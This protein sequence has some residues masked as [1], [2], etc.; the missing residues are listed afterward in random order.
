MPWPVLWHG[1]SYEGSRA[2]ALAISAAQA[3]HRLLRTYEQIDAF[4]AMSGFQKS[5][6][7]QAG[8]RPER[9]HVKPHFVTPV[10]SASR[11]RERTFVYVGQL[12]RSKGVFALL[13]A[14][15]Q[16]ALSDWSLELIGTGPDEEKIRKDFA[17][18]EGV[19]F[20]GRLP[21]EEA[22]ERV[23]E[24]RYLVLPTRMLE[25]FGL[26]AVEAMAHGAVALVS[27]LGLLP[28]LVADTG[29]VFRP[30]DAKDLAST[31]RRAAGLSHEKWTELSR[32]A[33]ERAHR[34]FS[35]EPNYERLMEIYE[36]ARA[37]S[38]SR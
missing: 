27:D 11:P 33:F 38:E 21:R 8:L 10:A 29:M 13:A 20:L 31:L 7:M 28:D 19:G 17:N 23:A 35:P 37:V 34:M 26:V 12:L 9:I 32:A 16:A 30:N 1:C 24:A 5:I 25:T 15:K 2:T 6:L 36:R 4:I 3:A 22:L 14:W 18:L